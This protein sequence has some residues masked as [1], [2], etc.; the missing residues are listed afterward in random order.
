[1]QQFESPKWHLFIISPTSLLKRDFL[2][3]CY[4]YLDLIM[5]SMKLGK[6]VVIGSQDSSLTYVDVRDDQ[7]NFLVAK[8]FYQKGK[9]DKIFFDLKKVILQN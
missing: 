4:L 8:K 7:N 1:M 2:K 9:I 3:E 6:L 5:P